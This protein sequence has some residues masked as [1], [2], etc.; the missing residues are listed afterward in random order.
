M[1]QVTT[2][3]EVIHLIKVTN[4]TKKVGLFIEL[5]SPFWFRELDR[6]KYDVVSYLTNLLNQTGWEPKSTIVASSEYLILGE[7]ARTMGAIERLLILGP[8][9]DEQ[10]QFNQSTDKGYKKYLEWSTP[11]KLA[12]I[13]GYASG[14]MVPKEY[15]MPLKYAA[16]FTTLEINWSALTPVHAANLSF[17]LYTFHIDEPVA[18]R[19]GLVRTPWES[20]Q[21]LQF[22]DLLRGSIDTFD[23]LLTDFPA[24]LAQAISCYPPTPATKVTH[25][26]AF[27]DSL[28]YPVPSPFRPVVMSHFGASGV[29]PGSTALAYVKAINDGADYIDCDIQISKDKVLFC[30]DELNLRKTT[31]GYQR[32]SARFTSI[33]INGG[34]ANGLY[35][36]TLLWDEISTL[37]A[38]SADRSN[39]FSLP[40]ISV[41]EF[42]NIAKNNSYGRA[43]GMY[44]KLTNPF[45]MLQEA[46]LDMVKVLLDLLDANELYSSTPQTPIIIG[47]FDVEALQRVNNITARNGRT[48]IPVLQKISPLPWIE[49]SQQKNA[50]FFVS[51]EGLAFVKQYAM[52]ISPHATQVVTTHMSSND[53][54]MS[55]LDGRKIGFLMKATTLIQDAR[56]VGLKVLPRHFQNDA[57]KPGTDK[58]GYAFDYRRD[59]TMQ[60]RL[61]FDV[62]GCDGVES[63]FP[64]TAI[65]YLSSTCRQI[66]NPNFQYTEVVPGLFPSYID[67][68]F[69][70]AQVPPSKPG[71]KGKRSI[72]S[73]GALVGIMVAI[74]FAIIILGTVCA[75][76][77]LKYRSGK[78]S[79]KVARDK[80]NRS[81]TMSRALSMTTQLKAFSYSEL[82]E[83]TDHFHTS[84]CLGKGGFGFVWM[85]VLSDGTQVAIKQLGVNSKQ[86]EREF[87][88]EVIIIGRVHNR[89]LVTLQGYCVEEDERLLVYDYMP[90]GS[91]QDALFSPHYPKRLKWGQLTQILIGTARGLAYLHHEC[92]HKIIHRDIKPGN[93]L[94]DANMQARVADFGLARNTLVTDTHVSTNVM[95]TVGYLAPDYAYSGQLTEKSDVFSFGV[96]MLVAMSGRRP[97]ETSSDIIAPGQEVLVQW[98]QSAAKE[99]SL[100]SLIHRQYEGQVLQEEAERFLWV[101]LLCVQ[102]EPTLR[103]TMG[104]VVHMLSGTSDI[105]SVSLQ[106]QYSLSFAGMTGG[107]AQYSQVNGD[108]N[109]NFSLAKTW[110]TEH[111][112]QQ[113]S[114]SSLTSQDLNESLGYSEEGR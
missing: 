24:A 26:F 112:S 30:R 20:S 65:D 80:M 76:V 87:T 3:E 86:G 110:Q 53:K 21:I 27:N 35:G 18:N 49:P 5:V 25:K 4:T 58:Y 37:R 12:E 82:E 70:N 13:Q 62:F 2:P 106:E 19:A 22:D 88:N 111:T 55:S 73:T 83:A 109:S 75:V 81:K 100:L 17:Y 47:S 51:P 63:A 9:S 79:S 16:Y 91:L 102:A 61:F 108:S 92:E 50:D 97:L 28:A 46:Q 78:P 54:N 96:V 33:N 84:R 67:S 45:Y 43:V 44:L 1:D 40:I 64:G 41:Q 95:G 38:I 6:Q 89:N 71:L 105:P 36:H 77:Y 57:D 104:Q 59:P 101:A 39:S 72:L 42:I 8:S 23:G 31:D 15:V 85:G 14:I 34:I 56:K 7:L 32:F 99:G 66:P 60:M 98:A 103:P 90:N 74:L 113:I 10:L 11:P 68:I 107:K 94:L 52:G 93:I 29:Y 48:P 114:R 69:G